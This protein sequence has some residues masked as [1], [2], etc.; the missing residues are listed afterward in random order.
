MYK[1]ALV[2]TFYNIVFLSFE[3]W[4]E[5]IIRIVYFHVL[6]TKIICEMIKSPWDTIV[7]NRLLRWHFPRKKFYRDPKLPDSI[8]N[9]IIYLPPCNCIIQQFCNKTKVRN[10]LS[11]YSIS[12]LLFSIFWHFRFKGH[13]Y[14]IFINA[15]L[16]K[17]FF[18]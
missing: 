15:R 9:Y 6:W 4:I 18:K 12:K 1:C 8:E 5:S 7:T 16:L 2:K 10:M 13:F 11:K 3:N 17:Y 14:D